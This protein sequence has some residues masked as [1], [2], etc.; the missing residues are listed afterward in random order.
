[1][2][3][4]SQN[5]TLAIRRLANSVQEKSESLLNNESLELAD[6]AGPGLQDQINERTQV[7][8][9]SV[10]CT[11]SQF[12]QEIV[13]AISRFAQWMRDGTTVRILGA[14]RARLAAAIPANRLAHGGAHVFLQDDIVP[15]P[16]SVRGGGILAASAS[17]TTQTVLSA[18]RSAR[19]QAPNI[20]I[21]GIAN[22][23]A[24]EF[25]KLCHIFIGVVCPEHPQLSAL[26]DI[27]EYVI[28]EMLDALVVAA[29]QACGY[30]ERAWRLG[31]ENLGAT[32]PYDARKL[33]LDLYFTS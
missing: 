4:D 16:H 20:E 13:A 30:D 21:V 8:A 9:E 24:I 19:S 12:N 17:G 27:E 5:E 2:T 26:A 31:H 11:A 1:M 3:R 28:S 33:A 10:N 15:M 25:A 18:M 7:I 32:G 14:G 23:R 22:Y 29:G 6:S